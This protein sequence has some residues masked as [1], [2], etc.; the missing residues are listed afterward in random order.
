M[1]LHCFDFT[2]LGIDKTITLRNNI[3]PTK[4]EFRQFIFQ[5]K[6]TPK[7]RENLGT[8]NFNPKFTGY[9]KKVYLTEKG[10]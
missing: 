9:K 6:L 8:A 5:L 4:N 7:I 2:A 1:G 10:V 3:S